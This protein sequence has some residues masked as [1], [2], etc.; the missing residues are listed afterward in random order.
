MI[1]TKERKFWHDPRMVAAN[2]LSESER[3]GPKSEEKSVD[4]PR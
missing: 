1:A 2:D 4:C 3:N